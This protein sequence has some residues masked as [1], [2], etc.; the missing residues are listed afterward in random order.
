MKYVEFEYR[1]KSSYQKLGMRKFS[2]QKTD[3]RISYQELEKMN[4]ERL[5]AKFDRTRCSDD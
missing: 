1:L 2:L 5:S 4:T 3:K